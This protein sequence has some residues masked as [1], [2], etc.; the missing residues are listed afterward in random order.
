MGVKAFVEL[1]ETLA[2]AYGA[3]FKPTALLEDM[4]AKG[5]TFYGRFD[6]YAKDKE[7]A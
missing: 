3:H 1:C 4:A 2:V 6:P 7:A 5:E